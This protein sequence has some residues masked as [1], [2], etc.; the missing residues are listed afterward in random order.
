M[1]RCLFIEGQVLL[2]L[3][4]DDAAFF[5][6]DVSTI[7]N[8]IKSLQQSFDLSDESKLQD[9]LG[10]RF[11]KHPDGCIELQ[12]QKTIDNCLNLL[13]LVV[14]QMENVSRESNTTCRRNRTKTNLE[15]WDV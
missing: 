6:P 10:S 14:E 2:V 9:Y 5:L 8:G 13:S 11:L 12:Q 4:I 3:Y 7:Q 1:D 15:T